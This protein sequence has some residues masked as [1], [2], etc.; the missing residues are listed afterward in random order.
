[1]FIMQSNEQN[2]PYY[3]NPKSSNT[4][5]GYPL[6]SLGMRGKAGKKPKIVNIMNAK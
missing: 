3:H 1:M 2:P 6:S 4:T 5:Q